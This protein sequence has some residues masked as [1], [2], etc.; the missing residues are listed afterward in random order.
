MRSATPLL[1]LF[2]LFMLVAQTRAATPPNL[3][4]FP[5]DRGH[6]WINS[7][8]LEVT[9]LRGRPVLIEFWTF[10]CGNC[11]ATL[12]WVKAVAAT[13]QS[14][15]LVVVGVHSPEFPT[16]SNPANVRSAVRTLGVEYPVLLDPDFAYWKAESNRYWPAFYL[17]DRTGKLVATRI[18][19]LHLGQPNSDEF[20]RLIEASLADPV[21]PRH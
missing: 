10:D 7:V 19:E 15:G 16:E 12:P 3:P 14:K 5:R 6:E 1:T 18:G 4:E 11:R 8:P 13:Y 20:V 9:Q 2:S 17:Y 21:A